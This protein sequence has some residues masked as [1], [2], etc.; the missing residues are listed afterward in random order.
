MS[1]GPDPRDL[2]LVRALVDAIGRYTETPILDTVVAELRGLLRAEMGCAYRI[3]LQDD[4]WH[5]D[6]VHTSGAPS[7]FDE[8]FAQFAASTSTLNFGAYDA[9]T[10]S[11]AQRNVPMIPTSRYRPETI[12]A[13]PLTQR[14]LRPHQL[15]LHAQVRVLVCD[16]PLLLGWVGVLG[17]QAFGA[18]EMQLLRALAEPLRARLLL[19]QRLRDAGVRARGFDA[20]LDALNAAAFLVRGERTVVHA[21]ATGR[22]LLDARAIDLGEVIRASRLGLRPRVTV[23]ELAAGGLQPVTLV[24]VAT[25]QPDLASRLARASREWRLTPRQGEVLHRLT[26]GEAN[27]TIAER[28]RCSVI[29]VEVHV[30]ALLR[31]AKVTSRTEL[32]ARFWL[33]G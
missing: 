26:L 4:A 13:L 18:R 9:L 30:S 27:K 1:K 16:G 6:F 11:K 29:T 20:A 24:I 22:A 33:E 25:P 32:I 15:D 17:T 5:L 12:A 28:L 10:P 21:N 23:I 31:K 19:E 14:L 8:R 2:Q 7:G 3:G